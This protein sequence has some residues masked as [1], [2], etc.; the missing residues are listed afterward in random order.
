MTFWLFL[1]VQH[2]RDY[3]GY[4]ADDAWHKLVESRMSE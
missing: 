3:F 4:P 1:A 2:L